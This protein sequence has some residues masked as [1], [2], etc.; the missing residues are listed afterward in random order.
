MTG[1]KTFD[2]RGHCLKIQK[3][4]C[5]TKGLSDDAVLSPTLNS[6]KGIIDRHWRSLRYSVFL[7]CH[8]LMMIRFIGSD[9]ISPKANSDLLH[10][11]LQHDDDDD[12]T[13]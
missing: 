7:L 11:R 13:A 3:R 5:R 12:D 1:P 8:C 9:L 10:P 6:F 4:Y 2:T